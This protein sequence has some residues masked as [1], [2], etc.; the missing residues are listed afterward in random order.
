MNLQVVK[1]IRFIEYIFLI[2]FYFFLTKHF[3]LFRELWSW[4]INLNNSEN[5]KVNFSTRIIRSI[6]LSYSTQFK[7]IIESMSTFHFSLL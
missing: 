6:R 1:V 7:L 4:F 2:W 5:L 3:E